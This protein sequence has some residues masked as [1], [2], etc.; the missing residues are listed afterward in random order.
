MPARPFTGSSAPLFAALAAHAETLVDRARVLVVGDAESELVGRLVE[1]GAQSVHVYDPDPRRA[2]E[3]SRAAPIG[4]LVRSLR[5]GL[6]VRDGMFDVAIVPDL[7]AVPDPSPLVVELRRVVHADGAVLAVARAHMPRPTPF[8]PEIGDA[9]V[10]YDELY[11]LFALAF[12]HVTMTGIVPFEGIVFAELGAPDEP[13]ISVDTSLSPEPS[14]DV[15]LV[16]ASSSALALD[17]YAIVQVPALA[18]A[19][20]LAGA[21]ELDDAAELDEASTPAEAEP[22]RIGEVD[23]DVAR[24]AEATARLEAELARTRADLAQSLDA[25]ATE[26]EA[27]EGQLRERAAFVATLERELERRELL[28]KELVTALEDARA[29]EMPSFAAS[30]EETFDAHERERLERKLDALARDAARREGELVAR[31]WRIAEL[32]AEVARARASTSAATA[33]APPPA[34]P[35]ATPTAAA[36]PAATPTSTAPT[37]AGY[38]AAFV[39]RLQDELDALRQALTQEHEARRAAELD[40]R[41]A[42]AEL[43]GHGADPEAFDARTT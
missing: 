23:A 39:G 42:R 2:Q 5:G 15:F 1:L 26:L 21:A 17:P 22:A 6:D 36:A 40:A 7:G 30:P 19:S 31:A 35:A 27:L 32:E 43:A 33:A 11:D 29:G 9:S 18:T 25:R 24:A 10:A 20:E 41:A 34:A 38:D 3:A 4:V 8:F 37:L 28:V 13:S 12:D 14:P 16:L